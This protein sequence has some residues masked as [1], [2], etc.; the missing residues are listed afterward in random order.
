M[1]LASLAG[2]LVVGVTIL[3]GVGFGRGADR[4][5]PDEAPPT[6]PL[7]EQA[8][9]EAT[10]MQRLREAGVDAADAERMTN[11]YSRMF[12]PLFS[13]REKMQPIEDLLRESGA[14]GIERDEE[15]RRYVQ[16][17]I[18]EA[19]PYLTPSTVED[20]IELEA[21]LI[22]ANPVLCGP[23]LRG[24][25]SEDQGF[26]ALSQL[27]PREFGRWL[28]ISRV[29]FRYAMDHQTPE[30]EPDEGVR[31][32]GRATVIDA[33][34]PIHRDRVLDTLL[35]RE[36]AYDHRLCFAELALRRGSAIMEGA[37]GRAYRKELLKASP[38]LP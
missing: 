2:V 28:G 1:L 33:L 37:S 23:L 20:R 4:N 34:L 18:R 25:A 35:N 32:R 15:I 27:T 16:G 36:S 38:A 5:D 7:Y 31:S 24:E 21:R 11:S 26:L 6:W 9:M 30:L 12:W 3:A 29:A 13:D 17:R 10:M 8:V 14:K 19:L 22:E